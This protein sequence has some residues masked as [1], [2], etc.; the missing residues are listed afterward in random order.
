MALPSFLAGE[1][2][3]AILARMLARIPDDLD[4][5]E[6]SYLWDACSAS[7]G[8]FAIM[9]IDMG[10][11]LERGFA[12]TTFGEY[13]DYRCG[14]K[15][16]TR[17]A[18]Q[19]AIDSVTFT[20]TEGTIIPSG[21]IVATPADRVLNVSSVEFST[22]GQVTIPVEGIV[23]ANIIA[24]IAGKSGNVLAN[25]I[26]VLSQSINGVSAVNNALKAEDGED[27]ESDAALLVRYLVKVRNPGTSGNKADYKIWAGEVTGVGGVHVDPLWNGNGTV[28][29]YILGT[30]MKPAD[31]VIIT[32]TQTYIDPVPEQGEGKAPIGATV[33][34]VAG[35]AININVSA[36]VMLED[37]TLE[38]VQTAFSAALD[39]YLSTLAFVES[40]FNP[41]VKYVRIGSLLLDIDGVQ[42]YTNL[43]VNSDTANIV[44]GTGE[45]A[46]KGTVTLS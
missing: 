15:G 36:A 8:E 22:V 29:L 14:E 9:K 2:E 4:K 25:T 41:D 45:V 19:K 46:V 21:T 5:S 34:V 40:P 28:K 42:D 44:I 30:D 26:T 12:Q 13:L 23:D 17:K 32:N 10:N 3:E 39:A 31:A 7:A 37:K 35:T 1:T 43:L 38:E 27:I 24:L 18:A 6:G 11:F 16:I 33:T 20:G